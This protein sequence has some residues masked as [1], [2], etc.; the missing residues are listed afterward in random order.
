[1]LF[2]FVA[3]EGSEEEGDGPLTGMP[4][5][6]PPIILEDPQDAYVIKNKPATL[7]CRAAHALKG[8]LTLR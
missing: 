4:D 6:S 7:T 2:S 5:N 8:K 1:M 3:E